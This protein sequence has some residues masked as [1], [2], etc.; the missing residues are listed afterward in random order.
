MFEYLCPA[1]LEFILDKIHIGAGVFLGRY[2]N[3]YKNQFLVSKSVKVR[4]TR[5]FI[6]HEMCVLKCSASTKKNFWNSS[7]IEQTRALLMKAGTPPGVTQWG[8]PGT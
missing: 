6:T 5:Q 2:V 7:K 3:P 1:R 8:T 4:P